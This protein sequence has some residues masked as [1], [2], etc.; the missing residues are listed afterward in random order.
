MIIK[1]IPGVTLEFILLRYL[2]SRVLEMRWKLYGDFKFLIFRVP[3]AAEEIAV[4]PVISF[5]SAFDQFDQLYSCFKNV[6]N[7]TIQKVCCYMS[8]KDKL[9]DYI[10]VW[11]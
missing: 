9:L 4:K 6:R 7:V 2:L 10:K 3:N 11:Q 8:N 5:P 1:G